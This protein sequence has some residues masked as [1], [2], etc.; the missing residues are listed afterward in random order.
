[1]PK[2]IPTAEKPARVVQA[3]RIFYLIVSIGIVRAVM[4]IIR[5]ADV[6]SPEFL[7]YTKLAIYVVSIF[8]IYQVGQR[9]NWA[10][11]SL[12][13]ILLCSVPLVI[14]PAFD[15]FSHNWIDSGLTFLQLALYAVGLTLI[16]SKEL[17]HWF[18]GE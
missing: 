2:T 15:S 6:R 7:I 4:T 17:G 16:F 13:L 18:T 10:R 12:S 3:Q 5:H 1:M 14:L 11:W 8:L 9:K